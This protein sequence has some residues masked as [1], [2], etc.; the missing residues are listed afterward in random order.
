MGGI[1]VGITLDY[2]E[3]QARLVEAIALAK[4]SKALP[5]QWLSYTQKLWLSPSKTYI[6][7]LGTGLLARATDSRVDA[8]ALKEDS[9]DNAYSAR[10][11]CHN[12]LVPASKNFGFDLRT[13]GREPLNNQPFFRYDRI[14]ADARV[15]KR[16]QA[17]Y[18]FL[19]ELLDKANEL[20]KE[21]ALE[22]LAAFLRVCFQA[23]A[24]KTMTAD[25][26][27]VVLRLASIVELTEKFMYQNLEGGKRPQG[28]VAAVFDM[29]FCDVR[30]SRVNAPSRDY[31]GDVKVFIDN[32]FIM[33][34]EVRAKPVFEFEVLQFA[35]AL[36]RSGVR[37]GAIVALDTSQESLDEALVQVSRETD[38]LL[39]AFY[40]LP[41]LIVEALM[42]SPY[43]LETIL[44]ELP[45]RI[46]KR[47]AEM[48]ISQQSLRQWIELCA[49]ADEK[50]Y[51]K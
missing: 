22:A 45:A 31:P 32:Q 8:L 19:I 51:R 25:L 6:P 23:A 38:I 28:I 21:Q 43:S 40:S 46:T 30:T 24:K 18:N 49:T 26:D 15:H 2:D 48:E 27:N 20:S 17:H 1:I 9:S 7:A 11:L 16:S 12:V 5:G 14:T 50:S 33:S 39:T 44:G 42:W 36:V 47:L 3:A 10:T 34:T 37:R 35:E 4:S 13:T 41:D 29:V